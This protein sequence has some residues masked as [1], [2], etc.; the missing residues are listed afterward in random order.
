MSARVVLGAAALAAILGGAALAISLADDGGVPTG[1]PLPDLPA[2][3]ALDRAVAAGRHVALATANGPVHV[4]IPAGYHADGAAT[5]LYV[6][7]YYTTIDEAWIDHRLPEQFALSSVNAVFIAPEAPSG[8]RQPVAWP[9]LEDLLAEV[10]AQVDVARPSGA[11]IA[12]GHSG[13]YRT[14][15]A[16]L[17][18]PLLDWIIQV[19]ATYGEVDA[20]RAWMEGSAEHHLVLIGDDT[21]RWTEELVA[22]LE[23]ALPGQVVSYDRFD[24]AAEPPAEARAARAVYVRSQYGHMPLVTSGRVLPYVLRIPPVELLPDGPWREPLGLPD[25]PDAGTDAAERRR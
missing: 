20:W 4:W 14:L 11:V 5:V 8:S 16:W 2:P 24:G 19:D 15:L 21:V 9:A 12:V 10:F 1:A 22:A 7:G 18:Y 3:T 25:R 17:D 6:H 13:A 23:A